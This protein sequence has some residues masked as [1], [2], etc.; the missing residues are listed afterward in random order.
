[1]ELWDTATGKRI[2]ALRGV[3]LGFHSVA[4]SPDGERLVAGSVGQEAIKMWDLHSLEEVATLAAPGF[5][6]NAQFSP[7]G[8]TI[9]ARNGNFWTAPG[10]TEIHAAERARQ[11]APPPP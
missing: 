1:V 4:F 8:N 9:V 2:A 5:H 6:F 3:L 11:T 10:W 7:N